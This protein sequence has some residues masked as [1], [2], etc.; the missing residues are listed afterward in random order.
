MQLFLSRISL[1]LHQHQ[2]ANQ[3]YASYSL[4][5]DNLPEGYAY[6]DIHTDLQADSFEVYAAPKEFQAGDG[7]LWIDSTGET[8]HYQQ[9]TPQGDFERW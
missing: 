3:S 9:D 1:E 7:A 6:Y 4:P 8:R 2:L 5:T